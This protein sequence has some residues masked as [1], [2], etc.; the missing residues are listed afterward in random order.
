[1][2]FSEYGGEANIEHQKEDVGE[3]GDC[4][5]FNRKYNETWGTK[6]HEIQWGVIARHPYLLAS[7]IWNMFDFATPPMSAQGG[8]YS[9]NMKGLVTFDRKV[10]KD[11]FTC[12]RPTGAE[13]RSYISRNEGQPSV[14][15]RLP[16]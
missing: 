5:G 9:R 3:I 13:S 16:P 11:P 1:M 12:T 7:Y 6:F 4:C 15:T 2:I 10:K 14:R 8:V